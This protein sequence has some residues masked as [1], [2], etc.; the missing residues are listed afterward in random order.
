MVET[1]IQ[2]FYKRLFAPDLDTRWDFC[3][4]YIHDDFKL[5]FFEKDEM[6]FVDKEIFTKNQ[7]EY[8]LEV[9]KK[10]DVKIS[11]VQELSK[12]LIINCE[13]NMETLIEDIQE[14]SAFSY[15]SE[16]IFIYEDERW[17]WLGGHQ[18]DLNLLK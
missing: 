4:D 3:L 7:C 17:K 6:F 8:P 9:L 16:Y 2:N 1:D 5:K 12:I 14:F 15:N 18:F 10:Y 11:E 13:E